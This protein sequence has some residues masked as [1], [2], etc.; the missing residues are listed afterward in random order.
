[1]QRLLHPSGKVPVS[2]IGLGFIS[3]QRPAYSS[4]PE[5]N[6]NEVNQSAAEKI[7]SNAPTAAHIDSDA[8]AQTK[9]FFGSASDV[10]PMSLD[11]WCK[12]HKQGAFTDGVRQLYVALGHA[13]AAVQAGARV[14][15]PD[16]TATK[17]RLR[18]PSATRVRAKAH[19]LFAQGLAETV[20]KSNLQLASETDFIYRVEVTDFLYRDPKAQTA[21]FALTEKA[22][23]RAYFESLRLGLTESKKNAQRFFTQALDVLAKVLASIPFVRNQ[24]VVVRFITQMARA[25]ALERTRAKFD[26]WN[27]ITLRDVNDGKF[28]RRLAA[29]NPKSLHDLEIKVRCRLTIVPNP[30]RFFSQ[31]A[32][33]YRN[34]RVLEVPKRD[35]DEAGDGPKLDAKSLHHYKNIVA[36]YVVSSSIFRKLISLMP[37]PITFDGNTLIRQN[38]FLAH[39]FSSLVRG[40]EENALSSTFAD[41][42]PSKMTYMD[43]QLLPERKAL[44]F[45]ASAAMKAAK[46]SAAAKNMHLFSRNKEL[47]RVIKQCGKWCAVPNR[48]Y[49]RM[50][51]LTSSVWRYA[52]V[53][54]CI[55]SAHMP[56]KIVN[57]W[58]DS[59]NVY[60]MWVLNENKAKA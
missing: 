34:I 18:I 22:E 6:N 2:K 7:K 41:V 47:Q 14:H 19:A 58:N 35:D 1:M 37:K 25:M 55:A 12:R 32:D 48:L 45:S 40:G 9:M 3:A 23:T 50:D 16:G 54:H 43:L 10:L 17:M 29:Q 31:Y 30:Q 15:C 42:L 26:D 28:D 11:A 52:A 21:K 59:T 44:R 8:I 36:T 56:F 53:R 57:V 27:V 4:E 46:P 24:P 38:A 13:A 51:S 39:R 5:N 33:I 49:N 60:P 20:R